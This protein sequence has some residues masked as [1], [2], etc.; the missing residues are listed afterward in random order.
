MTTT[1]KIVVLWMLILIGYILHSQ[2]YLSGL[3]YGVD[4][5]LKEATGKEP[6]SSHIMHVIFDILPMMIIVFS[7]Y[8]TCRLYRIILLILT[9]L[10][11]IANGAHFIETIKE[12]ADNI[13]QATLTGY[14]LVLNI[15]LV[16]EVFKWV[17]G[18]SVVSPTA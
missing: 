15:L 13:S 7:M 12:D 3:F 8:F 4:I 17:R 5:K 14:I 9:A 10:F 6:L 1:N 2:F 16:R 11:L 18:F